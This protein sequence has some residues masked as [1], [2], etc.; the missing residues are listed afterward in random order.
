MQNEISLYYADWCGHCNKFKPVWESMKPEFKSHG[1]KVNEYMHGRDPQAD[2]V[3]GYPTIKVN[4]VE[5]K[6]ERERHAILTSLGI[7]SGGVDYRHKYLKYKAK[8]LEL[9]NKIRN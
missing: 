8:Y 1:I 7:Q 3:R 2:E 6:G 4:G 9:K 5:Y